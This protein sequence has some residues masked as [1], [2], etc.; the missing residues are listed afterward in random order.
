MANQ[1]SSWELVLVGADGKGR[2]GKGDRSTEWL[3][4]AA[5]YQPVRIF[6]HQHRCPGGN[7]PLVKHVGCRVEISGEGLVLPPEGTSGILR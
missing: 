5:I 3:K 2:S 7:R 1:R 6:N 4:T